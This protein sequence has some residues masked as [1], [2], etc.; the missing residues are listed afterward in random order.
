MQ[1]RSIRI[2]LMK[3]KILEHT[4][5]LKIEIFGK[6]KEEL[7]SNALS[8]M[9][10]GLRAEVRS[11]KSEVR[12]INIKSPDLEALLVDFL[13]ECLYLVQVNKEIYNKVNFKKFSPSVNSGKAEIEAELSGQRVKRFNEDIKAVTYY[14]L[15]IHQE[16][17]GSW[18]AVVVF[19]I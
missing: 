5:D 7:F 17:D 9:I 10:D 3:Y 1:I 13:S 8:G 2:A 4:A 18:R 15:D 19:D 6:S 16:K 11:Q 14:D 12:N